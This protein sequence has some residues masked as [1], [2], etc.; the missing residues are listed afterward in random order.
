MFSQGDVCITLVQLKSQIHKGWKDSKS[1]RLGRT[2][3]K[4]CLL[5]RMTDTLMISQQLWLPAQ[6]LHKTCVKP[7]RGLHKAC[8]RPAQ[9]QSHQHPSMEGEE[10]HDPPSLRQ[11]QLAGDI[12]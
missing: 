7:A 9:D 2:K 6:G 5:V 11:D 3:G 4:E 10:A 1:Q 12:S 8:T